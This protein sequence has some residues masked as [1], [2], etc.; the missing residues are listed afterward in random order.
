MN[1]DPDTWGEKNA[2]QCLSGA[3]TLGKGLLFPC[4]IRIRIRYADPD[5]SDEISADPFGSGYE[6]LF[7][8]QVSL[9]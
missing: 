5:Q 9:H 2:D 8:L 6:T 3:E 7:F 4:N 1:A